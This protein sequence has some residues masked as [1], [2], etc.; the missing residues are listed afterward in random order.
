M[1]GSDRKWEQEGKE[2]VINPG[3]GA[4]SLSPQYSYI[5][6][7]SYFILWYFHLY[8]ARQ[9]Q[10]LQCTIRIMHSVIKGDEV[11]MLSFTV[12]HSEPS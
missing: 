6:G 11:H 12:S 5:F 7:G 1:A 2:D 4:L 8:I 3:K 9:S 10:V